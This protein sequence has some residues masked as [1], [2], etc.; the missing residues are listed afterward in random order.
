MDREF[1]STPC[2]RVP[3]HIDCYRIMF[4]D[5]QDTMKNAYNCAG[6]ALNQ[7]GY[8]YTGF[9]MKRGKSLLSIMNPELVNA[10]CK[11]TISKEGCLSLPGKPLRVVKRHRQIRVMFFD[12]M[13]SKYKTTGFKGF[14]AC[15]VQ[16]EM[17]HG[18]GILI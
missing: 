4:T 7:I 12:P 17:D 1:L 14:D 10:S 8:P 6:L 11:M 13:D 3:H 5:L 15:V 16:H 18:E 9:C 2:K